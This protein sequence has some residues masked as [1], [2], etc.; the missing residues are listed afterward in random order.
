MRSSHDYLA[1]K[2]LGLDVSPVYI[3]V[4]ANRYYNCA[5]YDKSSNSIVFGSHKFVALWA[6][7]SPLISSF[8]DNSSPF[9]QTNGQGGVSRTLK[10]HDA[11]VTC[12]TT[13]QHGEIVSGDE[14]GVLVIWTSTQVKQKFASSCYRKLILR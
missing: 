13:G 5:S 10:A 8:L 14:D 11:L 9:I 1:Q 2:M 3:S 4:A 7:V 12:V 6:I